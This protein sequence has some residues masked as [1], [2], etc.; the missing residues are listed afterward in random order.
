MGSMI[1]VRYGTIDDV[2]ILQDLNDEIFVDNAKY[3]S[4]L[5]LDW[6]QSEEGR[7]YFTNLVNN[8]EA[9]CLIAEDGDKKVGYLAASPKEIDYRK[10]K[11]FEVENMGVSPEYRSQGIGKLLLQKCFDYAKQNGFQKAFVISYANNIKAVEFYKRNGFEPIDIS[12]ER[13]L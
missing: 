7:K 1:T 4:D 10:S 8:K 3:D 12:L 13:E 2:K 9:L 6:A 11:Y 5:R